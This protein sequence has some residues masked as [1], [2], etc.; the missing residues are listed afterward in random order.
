MREILSIGALMFFLAYSGSEASI[1]DS[2]G[3]CQAAAAA[4][5][6][7]DVCSADR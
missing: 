4:S 5:G 7:A 2:E 3:A 1:Y 6:W